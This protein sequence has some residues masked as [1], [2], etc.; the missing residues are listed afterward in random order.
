DKRRPYS[1]LLVLCENSAG[2]K[3]L[4]KLLTL[5][6]Q[7]GYKYKPRV[8]KELLS[9]HSEGL[10]ASSACLGGEIPRKI[11]QGKFDEA[12]KSAEEFREI[13]GED[14]F[15]LEIQEHGLPSQEEVNEAI[16]DIHNKTKIP[17]VV[18][19]DVHFLRKED[20]EDHKILLCI[21][22][23]TTLEERESKGKEAYTKEHY[24]K[25]KEEMWS[26]F[27]RFEEAL[28]NSVEIAKRCRFEFD[29]DTLH[30]PKFEVPKGY[31]TIDYF[32]E[33]LKKGFEKKI[34]RSSSIKEEEKKIYKERLDFESDLIVKMGYVSYFLIVSDFIKFAKENNISVGPGRGSAAGSLVSY[35]LDIT[36]IDPIKYNLLFERFLNPERVSM[37]DIDIDFCVRGREKVIDYVKRKY[38]ND[39]VSQI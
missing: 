2:Y 8:D 6:Y 39:N 30:F 1:H 9:T 19:N 3:N 34:A 7:E 17:L 16:V 38:G 5:A 12:L 15:F 11:R 25:T 32:E 26:R 37:P 20:F 21:Q 33:L 24:F 23:K 13:F 31:S 10:I 27:N 4:C 22:T 18:T 29:F 35:C 36:D 28:L 14:N